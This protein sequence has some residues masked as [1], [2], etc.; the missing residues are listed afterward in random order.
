VYRFHG[1]VAHEWR[2]GRGLLAGDAAHQ[3][4]PFAGQGMC[5]GIRDA[6]NIA[7]KL[8]AILKGQ[9]SDT[10]LDS[11]QTEREPGVRAYI[12]L[13]ISMGQVVCT[14]D[15]DVAAFR[16]AD[17]IAQRE[18]GVEPIGLPDMPPLESI[19][20][21]GSA[22]A[23]K[24]VPQFWDLIAGKRKC[25]SDHIGPGS[26]M[27]TKDSSATVDPTIKL[28]ASSNPKFAAWKQKIEAWLDDNSVEAVLVRPDHY[29]FGSG[30]SDALNQ[31]FVKSLI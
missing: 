4:P 9:A 25:L 12:Q 21:K 30:T 5:S 14:L 11:Y 8:S 3:M 31:S 19:V 26:Y 15:P 7:W 24:R 6:A 28:V 10:L 1:L 22:W 17:M 18:A 29:A 16:D 2:K 23:G 27:L 20:L 13:A